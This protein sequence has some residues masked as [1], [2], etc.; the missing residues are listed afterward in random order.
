MN[1]KTIGDMFE[2]AKNV[3][4]HSD[5]RVK[6]GAVLVKKGSRPLSVGFNVKKFHPKGYPNK[7]QHAEWRA[8]QTCS[9]GVEGATIFV[10]REHGKTGLPML[11]KPC[12]N[13]EKF[14]KESGIKTVFYTTS[15]FPYFEKMTLTK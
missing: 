15:E 4:K 6:M 5:F 14:L 12:E 1:L 13:C 3:S 11:A 7:N 8:V 9:S 10:Y 2:L